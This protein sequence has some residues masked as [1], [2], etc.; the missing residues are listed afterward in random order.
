MIKSTALVSLILALTT[1]G[2]LA[3]SS[4]PRPSWKEKNFR[5]RSPTELLVC[6]ED[7]KD[8]HTG[9]GDTVDILTTPLEP[10]ISSLRLLASKQQVL[11]AS[12]GCAVCATIPC[13]DCCK[14]LI[15]ISLSDNARKTID[16]ESGSLRQVI[17]ELREQKYYKGKVIKDGKSFLVRADGSLMEIEK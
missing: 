15:Q 7:S 3:E 6:A 11:G 17:L 2:A 5:F 12:D 10:T 13:P 1:S 9:P 16:G 8:L 14:N 4:A